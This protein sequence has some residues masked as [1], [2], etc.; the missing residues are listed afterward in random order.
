MIAS[1]KKEIS[2]RVTRTLLMFVREANNGSLGYL[3]DGLDLSEEYLLNFHNWVSHPFLQILYDRMIDI[4]GDEDAVYKMTLASERFGSL[5]LLDRIVRL[6]ANPKFIYAQAPRYNKLL[7]RNGDV[8]IHEQGNSWVLLEDRYHNSSQKTRYDCDYTRGVLAGIPTMFDMPMAHVE[9]IECQ[10]TPETYGTRKWPDRPKQGCKGCLYRIHWDSM[11]TGSFQKR[12]FRRRHIYQ[13]AI[14]DLMAAN[15]E[16][17]EKYEEVKRLASGLETAN[18]N[19]AESKKQLEAYALNLEVSE[20]R[21]RLLAENLTDIIWTYNLETMRFTYVSPSVQKMRGFTPEEATALSLEETL[22]PSS[23]QLVVSIL[24]DELD[25]DGRRDVDPKRSRIVEVEQLRSDGSFAW[26]E[27]TMTFIRNE[28]SRPVGVLGITRDITE[29]K[30]AEE[31]LNAEKELL[32]V[33]LKSI[34]D[35]VITTDR[36]ARITLVNCVGEQLTGWRESE[37]IGMPLQEVFTIVDEMTR[38]AH[39]NPIQ[40]VIDSDK[41]M[42]LDNSALLISRD[43]NEYSIAGRAAPISGADKRIIGVVLVFRDITKTRRNEKEL[44]KI[45]KLESLGLLAGGIAHDFNNLLAGILGNVS[46]AKLDIGSPDDALRSLKATEKAALRAKD[47]TQQLLTFSKGGKPVKRPGDLRN[48][49]EESALF[50]LRGSKVKCEFVFQSNSLFSKVDKGQI[51]QVFHNLVINAKQAMPDGGIIRIHGERLNLSRNNAFSIEAAEYVKLTIQDQGIG[52]ED[53]HLKK[54][55]DPYFTTKQKG[56]GLG[57]AVAFSIIDKHS[58]R[59]IV[60]SELGIGSTFT[61]YL[62][63]IEELDPESEE[64]KIPI[65]PG[66]GKILFMDDEA[67]IRELAVEMIQKI[68]D[69]KVTVAKDGEEVIHLYQQALKEGSTFDAVILD[70]TVRGGMGGKEAIRRLREI[71]PKVRAIVCSGYST[72]PVMSNFRIYG[73]QEAV[74]KPYQ[75]QEMSKALN[76]VLT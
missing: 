43:G 58:G 40:E 63:A 12:L 66:T 36:H 5:G 11:S 1:M 46:L 31:R 15:R 44:L 3:L 13:K 33:T 10:V 48:L 35:G 50:A 76:S 18:E 70:L 61:I 49:I 19:L 4:L 16:I 68:G 67:F 52:I 64:D 45:E 29:R 72:D 41:I 8:Y 59:I 71:N 27:A 57:L 20:R 30:R 22:A 69:Y 65:T 54:I 34:G 23:L 2:C 62:P 28:D 9:E 26:A 38:K 6:T 39:E 73:F 17:Q 60:D 37:A 75:I 56:S 51:S 53:E 7:K 42:E 24:Q 74:K 32:A 25:K 14:E 55:F 21:Y 47:L